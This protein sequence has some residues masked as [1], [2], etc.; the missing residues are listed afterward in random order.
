MKKGEA[1][2]IKTKPELKVKEEKLP[3]HCALGHMQNYTFLNCTQ[4]IISISHYKKS[5]RGDFKQ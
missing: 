5:Q 3:T 1:S 4:D 2:S